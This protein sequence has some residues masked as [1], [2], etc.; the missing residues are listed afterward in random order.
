MK[1][2][3]FDGLTGLERLDLTGNS[4][5]SLP[6]NIFSDLISLRT[7]DLTDNSLSSLPKNI[8]SD[9]IS[10]RILDL[11]GNSLSSLAENAFPD[12]TNTNLRILDLARNSLSSL[13][14]NAFSGLDSLNSLILSVNSLTRLPENIFSGLDSLDTL[15]LAGNP[16]TNWP[17]AIANL[18]NL[19]ELYLGHTLLTSLP[20]NAFQGLPKLTYLDLSVNLFKSSTSLPVGIFEGLSNLRYLSLRNSSLTSLPP[21]VFSGLTSLQLLNLAGNPGSPFI[22]VMEPQEAAENAFRVR[23]EEGAPDELTTNLAV[24]AGGTASASSVTIP[25]GSIESDPVVIAPD[26]G[27]PEAVITLGPAPRLPE[28]DSEARTGFAGVEIRV[29]GPLTLRFVEAVTIDD[30]SNQEG[31]SLSFTVTL[32][33]VVPG[34]LTVTPSFTDQSATQDTDYTPNPAALTFAGTEGETKTFEVATIQDDIHEGDETFAV[35]LAVS[36]TTE[37]VD[38]SDAATGT[39]IDDD[40]LAVTIDDASNQEGESLSFTVTLSGVVPGGL[41]VTPSFTDQSATQDTDYTPNPA[42]LTFAGTEGETKT[43]EVATIQDD[44]HEGDETFA[45]TLAVSGTTEDVDASDAATGTIID[46][47]ALAVTIDDASNQEGESLSFTVT[48]NGAVSGGLTVTP[49]FMD[50]TATQDTDYT[51]NPAALTFAGTEGEAQTFEVATIQDDIHE[52]D[53][54]FTVTLAVSGTTEDVDASDAATGT[55]IDDDAAPGLLTLAVDPRTVAEGDDAT[56]IRVTATLD[57][58]APSDMTVTVRVSGEGGDGGER[59]RGRGTVQGGDSGEYLERVQRFPRW[60]FWTTR[61]SRPPRGFVSSAPPG[62]FRPCR[63]T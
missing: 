56:D 44:I 41:T 47:D 54:T 57:N 59:L 39:I 5:S 2:G 31:E 12:L 1:A 43:F 4:L 49:S 42:A 27:A 35:T 46:D 58:P 22:L 18:P 10:L 33:G 48:L 53:E 6:E 13:A 11:T 20:M 17:T 63:Y 51:P 32:S 21:G 3:D 55:I 9:L 52:G 28:I 14:E 38:A 37:D 24:T 25:L 8:F 15:D 23:V 40:A 7:L 60:Q 26:E 62:R 16:L 29:G 36:G 45:V 19:E 34:G 50:G 30:A 61:C